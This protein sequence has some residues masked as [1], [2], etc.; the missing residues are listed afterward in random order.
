M[1]NKVRPIFANFLRDDALLLLAIA[2]WAVTASS[3]VYISANL[4]ELKAI[5]FTKHMD[6]SPVS[7]TSVVTGVLGMFCLC[8]R[9]AKVVFRSGYKQFS[10]KGF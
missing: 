9:V 2:A 3:L 1:S 8:C 5:I 6:H 7:A 10:K 4:G